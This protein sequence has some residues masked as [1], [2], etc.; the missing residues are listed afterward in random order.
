MKK[1]NVN[2]QTQGNEGT[3]KIMKTEFMKLAEPLTV[4]QL[5]SKNNHPSHKWTIF[6]DILRGRFVLLVEFIK[7]K[8]IWR[9]GITFNWQSLFNG[10]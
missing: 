6:F 8:Y 1:W 9:N 7:N 10:D 5:I 3:K 2:D 4:I